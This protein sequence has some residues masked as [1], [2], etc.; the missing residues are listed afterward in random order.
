MKSLVLITFI[1]FL[2]IS[3]F[4]LNLSMRMDKDMMSTCPFMNNNSSVCQM[5]ATDHLSKWLQTFVA[6]SQLPYFV[7]IL[8][9]FFVSFKFLFSQLTLAPPSLRGYKR[10]YPESKLFNKLVL[11]FSDGLIHSKIP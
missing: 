4:G 2:F 11:A 10:D 9:V 5:P 6:T 1:S 7:I 3:L 8:T